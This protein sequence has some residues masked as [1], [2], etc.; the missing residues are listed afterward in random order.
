MRLND[1][2]QRYSDFVALRMSAPFVW[3][4][5]DCCLFAADCVKAMTGVEHAKELRGYETALQA[6][7]IIEDAGGLSAIA[8]AALG[9]SVTPA[10][11]AVGDVVLIENADREMLAI[12]NGVNV[13]APGESGIVALGMES[14]LAVWKV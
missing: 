9:P 10:Y 7:R 12:C 13:I 11:A 4:S 5:N 14:A 3:G 8:T 2:Q 1:W 6:A